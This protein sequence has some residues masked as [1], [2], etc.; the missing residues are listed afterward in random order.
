[1]LGQATA[2]TSGNVQ[3]DPVDMRP[4]V[5]ESRIDIAESK[6]IIEDIKSN[7]P[8]VDVEEVKDWYLDYDKDDKKDEANTDPDMAWLKGVIDFISMFVEAALWVVPLI[9]LFYLYRYRDYWLNLIQGRDLTKS[10]SSLPETLF[11]LD[12]RQESLPDNI[13]ASAQELWKN[14][15]CR[16]AV[17][18]LYRGALVA[19]FKEY[20]FDL[21]AGATEQDCIREIDFNKQKFTID[22]A[23]SNKDI[24]VEERFKQ[25]KRL[26]EVWIAIAY[27]HNLPNE[28]VFNQLN[29]NW[30]KFFANH[31]ADD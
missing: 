31:K 12:V 20:Q 24:A 10:E 16:E 29:N 14:N 27:A 7:K 25:F 18:L 5:S 21:P 30:N 22:D 9:I 28:T 2:D 4:P 1:V 6:S 26:T 15:K 13:E 19:L 11:G 3:I 17:S 8:F 23:K